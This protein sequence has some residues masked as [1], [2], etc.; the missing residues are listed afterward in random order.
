MKQSSLQLTEK[1][2]FELSHRPS[3]GQM[4]KESVDFPPTAPRPGARGQEHLSFRQL[5]PSSPL[6]SKLQPLISFLGQTE[7]QTKSL[8][9]LSYSSLCRAGPPQGRP[10]SLGTTIPLQARRF[11]SFPPARQPEMPAPLGQRLPYT[12]APESS[13]FK[14]PR[15]LW[16][17]QRPE[18]L[19][20]ARPTRQLE[21]SA[22]LA[23]R[24]PCTQPPSK[25]GFKI[26]LWPRQRPE[27]LQKA[28]PTGQVPIQ[29]ACPSAEPWLAPHRIYPAVG[30]LLKTVLPLYSRTTFS[31]PTLPS[32]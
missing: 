7:A 8:E 5:L 23:Q 6:Q 15:S 29:L 28:R 4:Q 27:G 10:E 25:F 22:R 24:L 17:R 11:Q 3:T 16:P 19:H 26:S 1:T 13:G 30:D 12:V 18:G 9:P 20:K 31:H 14:T 2:T 21:M 32:T